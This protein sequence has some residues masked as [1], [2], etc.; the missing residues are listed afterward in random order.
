MPSSRSN[1]RSRGAALKQTK[2]SETSVT[3]K[4]TQD[5]YTR[6]EEAASGSQKKISDWARDSLLSAIAPPATEARF[7][8][9]RNEILRG[10]V[11]WQFS[12]AG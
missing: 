9:Q 3:A 7:R 2:E 10:A 11:I 8:I 4:F 12:G 5:E 6:V 1:Y